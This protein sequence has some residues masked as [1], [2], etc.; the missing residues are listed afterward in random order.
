MNLSLDFT[1]S[2]DGET[3]WN[4]SVDSH[5]NAAW[6]IVSKMQPGLIIG[7]DD[8][9][10]GRTREEAIAMLNEDLEHVEFLQKV[11]QH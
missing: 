7:G 2:K 10:I 3:N 1:D 4:F 11:H 8:A 5:R 9:K 6:N